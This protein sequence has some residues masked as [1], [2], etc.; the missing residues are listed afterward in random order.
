[1]S[2]LFQEMCKLFQVKRISSTAWNPQMQGK[3]ERFHAGLNQNTSHYVNKNGNDWDNYVDYALM[4][5]RATPHSITKYSPYYLLYGRNMRLPNMADLSAL[6]EMSEEKH[7]VQDRVTEHIQ[8]L[9]GKLSE[10]H[11]VV[12]KLNKIGRE[13]QKAYYDR[14]AK[15]VTYSVG[16]YVYLKEM[17][18][19]VGKSRKF[20]NRWRGPYLITKRFSDLNYQIQLNPGKH[21]TVNVNRLKK[22]HAPPQKK[23]RKR[24]AQN[25]KEEPSADEWDSSDDEPL[26]LLGR[27]KF[28]RTPRDRTQG[29]E[30]VGI[31]EEAVPDEPEQGNDDAPEPRERQGENVDTPSRDQPRSEVAISSETQG[32]IAPPGGQTETVDEGRSC[33]DQGQPY[34]YS[35]RPLPGRRNYE[36]TNE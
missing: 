17:A 4:V 30:Y 3:V 22:C 36:S 14:N 2:A 7:E 11:D 33:N 20:R 24:T 32:V 6:M 23:S 29:S 13:K 19:G 12:Q 26:H 21:V 35:L 1:M 5:H 18:V 16:D 28:V 31:P 9:A 8:T 15:L 10:A 34:P 27:R 25:P